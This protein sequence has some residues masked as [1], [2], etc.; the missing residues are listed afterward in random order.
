MNKPRALKFGDT[1]GLVAPASFASEDKIGKSIETIEEMG[2]KIKIGK[3][4]YEKH[5]YLSGKDEIRAKDINEMFKD[6]DVDGIICLRGGYGTPRI[7]D[8]LDYNIIKENPKVFVGYSDITALHIVFNQICDLITFHGPMV[9]SDMIGN[10]QEF[11]KKS[12]FKSIME[13]EVIGLIGNP[14]G[15]EVIK[16][17]GGVVEGT[18][19][20]G[21]LSLIADTIGTAYEI[22]TKGKILL[23]EEVGEEPYSIDRMLNQLRLSGK[24]E[25][26]I[27]I[28]LG[29]FNDCD[30]KRHYEN[31]LSLK[32]VIEDY[33]KP[34]NKPC[35]Y[36]FQSGHCNPIITLPL[37][38][39]TRLDGDK[40]EVYMLASS[41]K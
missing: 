37:G 15:E 1:I 22:D 30:P 17:N 33:M 12:L 41:V 34:L 5:G 20:G 3:S 40:G 27:G 25:D 26:A 2:F 24:L 6:P 32:Q 18:I 35:I 14:P 4:I 38:I 36:N 9:S 19:I 28:I 29:D 8:L 23:I 13:N 21:N 10:F 11:S 39:N 16:I 7:L 31:S